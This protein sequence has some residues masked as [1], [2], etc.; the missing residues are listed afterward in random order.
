M[1]HKGQ[2]AALRLADDFIAD[3]KVHFTFA[4]AVDYVQRSPAA[5]ANLLRRMVALGLLD[6]VRRGRYV[7]RP[8]G[9]LGTRA[10]AEDVALAVAAAFSGISHR[11]GYR[12][13]LDEHDLVVHPT[14]TIHVASDKR[15]RASKLS[16]RPLRTV[17]EPP[18]T[19]GV[20]AFER[21]GAKWSDLERSLLDAAARP[22][23]IGGAAVLAEAVAA[24]GAKADPERLTHYAEQL[25]WAAALR[26]IGSVA[27]ALQLKGLSGKLRPLFAPQSD[28]DLEP[29]A[30]T[31]SVW[32]DGRWRVRWAQCRDELANVVWQ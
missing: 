1:V 14:R 17:A 3:G 31:A 18:A 12:S 13:A 27:D 4:E 2:N 16:G 6:R 7:V 26:R 5:T 9:A 28:L 30:G 11:I 22:D 20:G 15:M 21:G 10:A 32:R 29:A 23:L 8:F 25:N 24:A 19:V